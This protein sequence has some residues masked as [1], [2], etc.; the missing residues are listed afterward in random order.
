MSQFYGKEL[1]YHREAAGLTLEKLVEGSYYGIGLLSAI[2]HGGRGMPMDLAAHVDRRLGTDFFVR[3]CE[4]VQEARRRGH[5]EY[6]ARV[7]EAEK[8]ATTIEEWSPTLIPGLLQTEAYARTVIGVERLQELPEE[9]DEKVKA[10]LARAQLFE[11]SH[12]TPEYWAILPETLLWNAI[13]PPEQMAEQL[14][15][16]AALIKRGR[17]F[18]QIIP[19]NSGAHTLMQSNIM[20]LDFA[21][22][23][24]LVYMEGQHHGQTVDDP[25]LVKQYRRSYDLLR[26]AASPLGASLAMIEAAAEEYRNGAQPARLDRRDLA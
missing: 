6:F 7:L 10:R 12:Q 5:A 25:G 3:R 18:V 4:D 14:D 24:P 9:T 13:L 11:D 20:V 15:H 22:A 17:I 1:R 26:A 2:E 8:Q 23:P 21:D 19:W 16:I